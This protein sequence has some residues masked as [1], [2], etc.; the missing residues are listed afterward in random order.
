MHTPAPTYRPLVPPREIPR[1]IAGCDGCGRPHTYGVRVCS[2]AA[3]ATEPCRPTACIPAAPFRHTPYRFRPRRTAT[4]WRNLQQY[5]QCDGTTT[6]LH[7]PLSTPLTPSP[8]KKRTLKPVIL[9][10]AQDIIV[11]I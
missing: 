7:F 6:T 3:F 5:P 1:R 8:R 9:T 4:V 2:C 10:L 11:V